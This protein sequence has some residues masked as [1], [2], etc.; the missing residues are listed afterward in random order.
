MTE[1]GELPHQGG[2]L[3]L[4][5]GH[6]AL[7]AG[8]RS[9]GLLAR[10]LCG[11]GGRLGRLVCLRG[12]LGQGDPRLGRRLGIIQRARAAA[13]EPVEGGG[14]VHDVV[15]VAPVEDAL[16]TWV[17]TAGP[18][19][20]A[21]ELSDLHLGSGVCACRHRCAVIRLV[22]CSTALLQDG[23]GG[24]VGV[25]HLEGVELSLL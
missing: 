17:H 4:L 9:P 1:G 5:L 20:V 16:D 23:Q 3:L 12:I 18:V 7:R 11:I 6:E 25:L 13:R 2:P 14:P 24:R 19:E 8:R 15:E 21:C 10:G 22:R